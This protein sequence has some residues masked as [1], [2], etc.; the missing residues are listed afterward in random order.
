MDAFADL[1]SAVLASVTHRYD[2]GDGYVVMVADSVSN[3]VDA[4][5]PMSVHDALVE[6]EKV[7]RDIT[8]EGMAGIAIG[9]VR[10]QGIAVDETNGIGQVY[11]STG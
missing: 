11:P 2:D 5:G 10:L 6:A 9:V 3:E 1:L 8:S 7:G 4:Y